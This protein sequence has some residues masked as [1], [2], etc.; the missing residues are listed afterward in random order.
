MIEI[1]DL[2]KRYKMGDNI[3]HALRGVSLKIEAGEFV[4]I[5]GPSGSGK[6]TLMHILGLLDVPDEGSYKLY[7]EEVSVLDEVALAALRSRT[8]G[9]IFQQFNLLARTSAGENVALPQIYSGEEPNLIKARALL[10]RVGLGTRFEHRPNELSGGQQQRVA[11]ARALINDPRIIFADE[12]TGNLDSQSQ[13]EIMGLLTEL[14]NQGITIIL[15]THET[16]VAAHAKRIVR[17]RDGQIQEDKIITPHKP[18]DAVWNRVAPKVN[19]P[20][21][22]FGRLSQSAVRATRA[23]VNEALRALLANKLR[24]VLSMLGIL[25]GVA[26]VIAMLALGAGAKLSIEKEL[27]SLGTNL[28]TLS[29]GSPQ[30]GHVSLGAGMVSKLTLDDGLDIPK[31]IEHV[32]NI[33]PTVNGRAQVVFNDKNWNTR[34]IGSGPGYAPMRAAV[35]VIGRFYTDQEDQERARVAVIGMTVVR[36]LFGEA[37]PLGEMVRINKVSF[38]VVGIL[39]EKGAGPF[40]D[41]D[42]IVVVPVATAMRRLL[43]KSFLDSV[44][45]EVDDSKNMTEVSDGIIDLMLKRHRLTEDQSD[46]FQVR[47]LADI[48]AALSATSRIMAVLLAV[49]ASISLVV[50][51]IGIM[52][53]MLVSVTERIR[54]IGLRK[55]VGARPKDIL[56]QFLIEAT[57]VS[58]SGGAFGIAIGWGISATMSWLAGWPTTVSLNSVLLASIFSAAIGIIFGL[59]PARKASRLHPIEALRHD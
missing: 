25:I 23:Y 57:V 29:T 31:N 27:A 2:H 30:S 35:P 55:A 7:G 18:I 20:K 14:N 39:P 12:P 1:N 42:D 28:L 32:K 37:N 33:A 4:A 22:G 34:I 47:N 54:E 3:V 11:I 21:A 8:V 49:I 58:V 38:Q 17:V 13:E 24:T 53:I 16:E 9:F 51:G 52:N 56:M 50:G 6:S 26:A 45:I 41:Q 44:D 59:W 15:V 43:G 46:A 48:Q 5:M 10:E 36:N 19:V 40:F